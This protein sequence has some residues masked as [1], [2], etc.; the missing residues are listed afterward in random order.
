MNITTVLILFFVIPAY[1][2]SAQDNSTNIDRSAYYA[3][4]AS[5]DME[6]IEAQLSL[7]ED[8]TFK[9]KEA[10]EGAL[11]MKKAEMAPGPAK[12]LSL[13]KAGHEKLE[14]AISEDSANTEYRFLRL[15]IQENAPKIL[16]YNNE[17]EEDS[18][19]ILE[20]IKD[21]SATIQA[22]ILD[23]SGRSEILNQ[24]DLKAVLE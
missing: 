2:L 18:T 22:A 4:F 1:A 13:F 24:K 6:A 11:L 17:T 3:V 15:I 16:G 10:F 7:L 5:K 21:L 8:M 20:H 9:E 19:H 12:K 23:Y 14:K